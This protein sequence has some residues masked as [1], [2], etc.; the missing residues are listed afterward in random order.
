[1]HTGEKI[2]FLNRRRNGPQYQ[3]EPTLFAEFVSVTPERAAEVASM[4]LFDQPSIDIDTLD[5]GPGQS[6]VDGRLFTLIASNHMV[7]SGDFRFR[8]SSLGTYLNELLQL[9]LHNSQ[10]AGPATMA[11]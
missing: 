5:P 2:I 7:V 8:E 9:A 10:V 1:M 3:S 4:A 11:R 6:F